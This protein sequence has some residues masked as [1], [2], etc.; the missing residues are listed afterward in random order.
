MA[1]PFHNK[2]NSNANRATWASFGVDLEKSE[3][4]KTVRVSVCCLSCLRLDDLVLRSHSGYGS[5][6]AHLVDTWNMSIS[7]SSMW[8]TLSY[9]SRATSHFPNI[10]AKAVRMK[11]NDFFVQFFCFW[12]SPTALPDKCLKH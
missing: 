1:N 11:L 12:F 2:V 4:R 6:S 5:G 10:L 7:S 3:I 9:Q 8:T